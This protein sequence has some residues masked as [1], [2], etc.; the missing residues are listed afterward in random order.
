MILELTGG[1]VATD[2]IDIFFLFFVELAVY[3]SIVFVQKRNTIFNILAGISLG[4]AVLSKWL[5]G[6]IVLP[7]WLLIVVDAGDFKPKEIISQFAIL[8]LTSVTVFLPWQIYIYHSFPLEANWEASYN[9]K[10]IT[11]VLSDQSGPFYYFLNKIRINYGELIYLPLLWFL[12]KTLTIRTDK[13]LLAIST[14][15]LIPFL[16]F[17]FAETKMQAYILFVSPALFI[18]T[19][20]FWLM[21]YAYRNQHKWKW[22]FNLILFLLIALPVRYSIERIKPF[23]KSDR[24]PKWV[25]DLKNLNNRKIENGVLFNYD[26]PIEAM[27]YTNMVVYIHLPDKKTIDELQQKGYKILISDNGEIPAYIKSIKGISFIKISATE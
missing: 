15:F 8:I 4:A 6:L 20:D 14:W 5:P 25:T 16:F 11:E 13:K 19:A 26:K 17:S 2:H 23:E 21:M 3:Q 7:I 22:I 18:M 9:L 12:W 1:R 27:F 24:N 10:H